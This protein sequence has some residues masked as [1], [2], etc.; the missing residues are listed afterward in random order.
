[1]SVI[2]LAGGH[3][4]RMGVDKALLQA[5]GQPLLARVV[6]RLA[7]LSDDVIVSTDQAGRY[8]AALDGLGVREVIDALQNAGPLS[9]LCAGLTAARYAQAVAVACDM[10]FVNAA[11]LRWMAEQLPGYDAVVPQTGDLAHVGD[12]AHAR[13]LRTKS[14]GLHPL[15][16]IY[17]K[18]CL[19]TIHA[20]L[21]EGERSMGSLLSRLNARRVG[22]DDLRAVDPRLLSLRNVNTPED[23][24]ECLRLIE[25]E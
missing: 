8:T 9:G 13:A 1:M 17:R 23:W 24:A 25:N 5:R 3:S 12:P 10:P 2:V 6:G 15:H 7:G 20:A 14:A 22:I 18:S 4:R 16:A 21:D 11:L 19:E